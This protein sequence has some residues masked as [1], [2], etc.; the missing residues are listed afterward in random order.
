MKTNNRKES[1]MDTLLMKE[2]QGDIVYE[3]AGSILR[4]GGL[5]AFPTETVYGLGGNALDHTAAEKIYAAKGRPSDNPLIVHICNEEM[6]EPLVS[7]IH[8]KARKLMDVFWPGPLT[9]IFPKTDKVPYETTGGLD[10][11][12]IRFPSHECARKII[13]SANVPIAAPSANVSGR[14]SPTIAQH[15]IEDM[16]GR[17]DMIVDGGNVGIGV[18]ST[19]VDVSGETPMILRPGFVTKQMIE[20]IVGEV[21][22]DAAVTKKV[23]ETV[24]PKAPGMKYRHYAP[25]APLTIVSGKE[26]AVANKILDMVKEKQ[27]E[28]QKVGIICTTETKLFYL[29]EQK[30]AYAPI[31]K[32][33]GSKQDSKAIAHNLYSI[34]R[35]FDNENVSM[36]L[37]EDVSI[38][39][40]KEAIENRLMKAAGHNIIHV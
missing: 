13:A 12:A 30:Q 22:V 23:S 21:L 3:K 17:I 4:K 28:K 10:T 8:P 38:G 31:I 29:K 26:K 40:L 36:I 14:P 35:E 11:V 5:V 20:Q 39:L 32:V 37:S 6:M 16:N 19:I 2:E 34:L 1:A 27:E 7:V 9:L 18:E 33:I 15:V 24:H 25:K